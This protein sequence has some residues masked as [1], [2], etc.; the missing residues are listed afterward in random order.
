MLGG[1]IL[2]WMY[3][4][5]NASEL[6]EALE[7]KMNWTWMWLSFPFGV[8]A[9]VFRALRWR[10]VLFP[11]GEKPRIHTCLNA[12]FLS[13]AS[14]LVIPRV[15]EV[16]RCAV[17]KRYEGVDFSRSVGT[18]VT[19]RMVDMLAVLGIAACVV[20]MQFGT[21]RTFFEQTGMGLTSYIHRFT[22]TECWLAALCLLMLGGL[23]WVFVRRL[24]LF[25]RT[26]AMFRGLCEGLF[27]L[28]KVRNVPLFLIYSLG[29]WVAYFLHLY[30]T[31]FCF[32]S[33]SGLGCA[34]AWVAFVVGSFAVLVPTPNGA[35]PWHFAVKTVL[36]MY[37]V[38]QLDAGLFV[39]I[40]HALQTLLVLL[41]GLY[42]LGALQ[43]TRPV[44]SGTVQE[45]SD[46]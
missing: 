42:A 23:M 18:V 38:S 45:G 31:F 17:L 44:R 25:R 10:Q 29:I 21:F 30:L 35:G 9:Q 11:L 12:V 37:G 27:S 4:G 33:T 26:Q 46:R 5:L 13:Y 2:G 36:V 7:H 41:L 43:F 32:N 16:L 6:A 14:S 19:E 39:L 40:V 20:L 28:R 22:A 1:A 34:A 24:T 8:W 3:R 15:G